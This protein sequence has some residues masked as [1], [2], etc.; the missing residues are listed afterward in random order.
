[1][2]ILIS[3]DDGVYAPGLKVL[4]SAM[5]KIGKIEVVAPL[6][7]KSTMG[8]SLTLHKPLRLNKMDDGFYGINGS[9]ADCVYM[10]IKAVLKGKPDLV[11]S[12]PNRGGNMGQDVY[13]SGTV[14]AAREACILGIPAISISVDVPHSSVKK[15]PLKIHYE[16]AA[17]Y[18]AQFIKNFPLSTI[19]KHTLLNINVPNVPYSKL[20]GEKVTRL[21]FRHYSGDVVERMD[22]RGRPYYWV[23][24]SYK[25]FHNVSGTDCYTID[26]GYVS[27]T[28]VQLDC[29]NHGYL[30]ALLNQ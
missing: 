11:V 27:I 7:E 17:K 8:H 16:T 4:A 23:G 13:Y 10:A 6:E 21:G 30:E 29:T 14:S 15:R 18:L 20:K 1:M 26:E 9:P 5:K 25:G 3:N 24:G 19:P 2:K 22:H 12:G 28:P